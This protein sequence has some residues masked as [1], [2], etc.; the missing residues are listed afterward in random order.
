MLEVLTIYYL[1]RTKERSQGG[2]SALGFMNGSWSVI[3]P[4]TVL[5]AW[6]QGGIVLDDDTTPPT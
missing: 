2:R 5:R 1:G 6:F 4:E 3:F